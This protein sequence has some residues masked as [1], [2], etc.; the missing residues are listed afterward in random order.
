[1][2]SYYECKR[3]VEVINFYFYFQI[4]KEERKILF[5]DKEIV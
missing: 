2:K 3:K 5:F 4:E 1:M